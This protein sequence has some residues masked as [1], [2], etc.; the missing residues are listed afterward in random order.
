MCASASD[1]W[2]LGPSATTAAPRRARPREWQGRTVGAGGVVTAY[3][4]TLG[5]GT[6]TLAAQPTQVITPS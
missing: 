4:A 1:I 3:L 2:A 6:A 5:S